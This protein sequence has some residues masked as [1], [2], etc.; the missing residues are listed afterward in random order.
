MTPTRDTERRHASDRRRFA[1]GGRRPT[2][3]GG[4]SP[5]VL[6]AY[7]DG[8]GAPCE[9]I[10]AAL[11]FAVAPANSVEETVRVM[12]VLRPNIIVSHLKENDRLREAMRGDPYGADLPLIAIDDGHLESSELIEEIRRIL[13]ERSTLPFPQS[14]ESHAV[15]YHSS[16]R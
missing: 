11:R 10:L 5:L 15:Q 3:N 4:F 2:D 14:T 7:E 8:T 13:R 6:V 1:R 16:S 9:E 12:R